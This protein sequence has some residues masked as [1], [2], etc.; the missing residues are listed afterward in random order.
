MHLNM[1][2]FSGNQQGWVSITSSTNHTVH[3][4]WSV[5]DG[6]VETRVAAYH[7]AGLLVLGKFPPFHHLRTTRYSLPGRSGSTIFNGQYRLD[8]LYSAFLWKRLDIRLDMRII[9]FTLCDHR[10]RCSSVTHFDI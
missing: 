3:S 8:T 7:F 2:Y 9:E 10:W 6:A 1:V 5:N 4:M